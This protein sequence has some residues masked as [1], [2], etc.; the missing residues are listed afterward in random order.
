MDALYCERVNLGSIDL[1]LLVTLDALLT[2]RSVS[3]AAQQLGLS[4]PAT[5]AQVARLRRHFGDDLLARFGNRYRLTPLAVQLAPRVRAAIS[6]AE[7]VFAAEPDFDP[8]TSTREF[9][10]IASDYCVATLG[11][12]L[13][14]VLAEE[15]PG[16]RLRF[17][18]LTT[19]VVDQ[20]TQIISGVDLLIL[21]HGFIDALSRRDLYRDDWVCLV[22]SD[23]FEVG[24]VLT[25]ESL[26]RMPWVVSHLGPT[27]T[28]LAA[29]QL[30][31]WGLEPRVQVVTESFMTVPGF[32]AGTPRVA[33][34]QQRLA[35]L[36]PP[37]LGVLA[38]PCPVEL[39]PVVEAMWWHPMLDDDPEHLFLR[40]AL[41]R[42][43][44]PTASST[45]RSR[46]ASTSSD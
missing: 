28:T 22:A 18:A 16:A 2:H 32:V 41:I 17:T 4:Q 6:S 23:H 35:D 40:E 12:A 19:Q 10:I 27:A 20:F 42:I 1:N 7:R 13:S 5:S 45:S 43:S 38:L 9:S 36:F 24:A 15:A 37:S 34:L 39:D 14:R 29:R 30:Q 26:G 21:P 3:R 11:P 44:R 33:L 46:T 31:T 25:P 8:A